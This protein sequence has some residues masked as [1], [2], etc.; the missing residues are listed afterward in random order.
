LQ[1]CPSLLTDPN[2][3]AMRW[4]IIMSVSGLHPGAH[5]F[6]GSVGQGEIHVDNDAIVIECDGNRDC[7]GRCL[8]KRGKGKYY[9]RNDYSHHLHERD[10]SVRRP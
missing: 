5:A 3:E 6:A 2:S 7:V 10:C 8:N 1:T 4:L 9:H